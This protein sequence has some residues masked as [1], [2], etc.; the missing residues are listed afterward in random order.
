MSKTTTFVSLWLSCVV[1]TS[2]GTSN[3]ETP[4]PV[5]GRL[6]LDFTA[7]VDG[8]VQVSGIAAD[9]TSGTIGV[10]T[11]FERV[12]LIDPQT[13]SAAATFSVQ[14]GDLPRQGS[15]EAIA[16]TPEGDVAILYPDA[17]IVR[18]Y[19]TTG[20]VEREIALQADGPIYGAMALSDDGTRIYLVTG[21]DTL[22]L[23]EL[24]GSDGRSL[25][26]TEL[27][28]DIVG[29]VSG[30]SPGADGSV[31]RLYLVTSDNRAFVLDTASGRV[32]PAGAVGEVDDSSGTEAFVNAEGEA[33]LAV[34]DDADIYNTAP[35]P[36]RVY[37][38]GD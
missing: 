15:T 25:R 38:L 9:R 8:A 35:G 28:G 34:S 18:V 23:V 30:L 36:I 4:D 21:A 13:V 7:F 3:S 20:D 31:D 22:S 17:L 5:Q 27:S 32:T 24:D 37:L 12:V 14:L 29:E 1:A 26:S 6:V 11:D 33:V 19:S 16:F 2:C 10:V